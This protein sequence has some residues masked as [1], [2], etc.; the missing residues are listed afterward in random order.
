MSEA[1][2]LEQAEL[3]VWR[4]YRRMKDDSVEPRPVPEVGLRAIES[5][6]GFALPGAYRGLL[7]RIGPVGGDGFGLMDPER[8]LEATPT[9]FSHRK[10][11][12]RPHLGHVVLIADH[13]CAIWDELVCKGEAAGT[14][15]HAD[16]GNVDDSP[17][18]TFEHYYDSWLGRMEAEHGSGDLAC[19]RCAHVLG[20]AAL[21]A[22]QCDACGQVQLEAARAAA[23]SQERSAFERL[24]E[25]LIRELVDTDG[26]DV[27]DTAQ[28]SSL[29]TDVGRALEGART[30]REATSNVANIL[31][32]HEAIAEL[33]ADDDTLFQAMDRA[34]R[35]L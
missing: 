20:V 6:W 30:P 31:C 14:V 2:W 33:Y 25:E 9:P 17:I 28:L 4:L 19:K 5:V 23:P 34:S 7:S 26:I 29:A 12:K 24:A 8:L 18:G 27:A 35:R 15:W 13:G 10:T 1:S 11:K 22:Y 32:D 16:G 21:E 3:R